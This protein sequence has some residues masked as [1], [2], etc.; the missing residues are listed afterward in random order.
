MPPEA[1]PRACLAASNQLGYS[2]SGYALDV[3][4]SFEPG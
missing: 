4:V 2:K 1:E 3:Y